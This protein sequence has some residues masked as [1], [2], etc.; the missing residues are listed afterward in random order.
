MVKSLCWRYVAFA[1]ALLA[2]GATGAANL[3]WNGSFGIDIS[4]WSVEDPPVASAEFSPNG[5]GGSPGSGSMRV[6]NF[7]PRSGQ[8]TGVAQC[9]SP[10]TGG[11]NYTYSGKVR[12]PTGQDRTGSISFGIIWYG[13]SDCTGTD[14]GGPRASRSQPN[15]AFVFVDGGTV[16]APNGANSASFVAYPSKVQA[17]SELVGFFDDLVFDDGLPEPPPNYQGLWWNAPSSSESGWGV[18]LA[19]QG[20]VIFATWFTYGPDGKPLW[21]AVVAN[22]VSPGVYTGDLFTTTGPPFNAVPFDPSI[23]VETTVGTATFTF[24][25]NNLGTFA[26]T[27]NLAVP[28]K[29]A[30]S[31]TKNITRQIYATPAPHCVWNRPTGLASATNY[32]DL[33]WASPAGSESGW[34]I[35]LT[36]QR[37]TIFVTWFTYDAN[38]NPLWL[39]GVLQLRDGGFYSG[40]LFTTT[41]P[42]FNAVPFD[43]A[44][45][46]ETTVGEARL[47]FADGNT[48]EFYYVVNDIEQTKTITRQ[49]FVGLGTECK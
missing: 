18:N 17:G 35:N 5:A 10:I 23:V 13:G 46:V 14:F 43:P 24:L 33:W 8:G 31:Q 19:H 21:L 15:D 25:D 34:G 41:G 9:V 49:V 22:K 11:A 45:V 32:Q 1:V 37:D 38:G 26:Y 16:K 39:A 30:I 12:Y 44:L 47:T 27:V 36:H 6:R 20:D 42:P 7:E 48:A 3:L 29:A 2:S 28:A 40:G 4:P